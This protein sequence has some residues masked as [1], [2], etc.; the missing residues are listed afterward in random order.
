MPPTLVEIATDLTKRIRSDLALTLAYF[1]QHPDLAPEKLRK[2]IMENNYDEAIKLVLESK[3]IKEVLVKTAIEL[4]RGENLQTLLEEAG[5][6]MTTLNMLRNA[7]NQLSMRALISEEEARNRFNLISS[8]LDLIEGFVT[9]YKVPKSI[10][11]VLAEWRL[12]REWSDDETFKRVFIRDKRIEKAEEKA[13]ENLGEKI[14][15][16]GDPGVGKTALLFDLWRAISEISDTALLLPNVPIRRIHEELGII[17]FADDLP[18]YGESTL[19]SL[20]GT[21]NIIATARE[22][23]YNE[24][25]RK[26]PELRGEF[27]TIYLSKADAEFLRTMLIQY[28]KTAKIPYD[29]K[30]LEIAVRKARGA[31]VYLW[32]L[33]KDLLAK[34][35]RGEKAELDIDTAQKIPEGTINY[36]GEIIASIISNKPGRFS[37]ILALKA[38]TVL[39]SA[40]IHDLIFTTLYKIAAEKMREEANWELFTT[41]HDL[42]EYN[43]TEFILKFPH[44]SWIDALKG[45]AKQ[46][47]GITMAIDGRYS[48]LEKEEIVKEAAIETWEKALKDIKT[49]MKREK[50]EEIDIRR[51]LSLAK[52]ILENWNDILLGEIELAEQ[53]AREWR[54]KLGEY[55]SHTLALIEQTTRKEI[56]P[57]TLYIK[58][59]KLYYEGKKEEAKQLLEEILAMD[60]RNEKALVLLGIIEYEQGNPQKA[61]EL[62]QKANTIEAIHNLALIKIY[63]EKYSE[64]EKLLE[65]IIEKAPPETIWNLAYVQWK[66]GKKIEAIKNLE[67]YLKINPRDTKARKILRRI[68]REE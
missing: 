42:M 14:L 35:R 60:P 36:V 48:D 4:L 64:A 55:A 45:G 16:I 40:E 19:K 54:A 33:Y 17:L 18:R 22:F 28:L 12:P 38:I 11:E 13:L 61:Q 10:D 31:P 23:E 65:K 25:L 46:I 41:I 30:A 58:A 66:Q 6:S 8:K 39:K 5:N 29:E 53:L 24:M 37:M 52:N 7:L 49:M 34:K 63:Q 47:A 3:E 9:Y 15:I 59:R 32:H 20:K 2:H 50:E 43:P 51:F 26:Y 67:K 68:R 1:F 56:T 62:F 57:A 44:D 21:K 27:K